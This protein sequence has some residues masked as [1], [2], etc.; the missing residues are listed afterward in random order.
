MSNVG[1]EFGF[2][3][4][5]ISGNVEY[6]NKASIDLIY[7]KPLPGSTGN[8]SITTNIGAI[9]NYGWEIELSSTNIR[10]S[11]FEWKTSLNLSFIKNEITK[12]TQESFVN[13]TK[14]WAVG[15]SLYDFHLVEWAGV[16]PNTGMGMWWYDKVDPNTGAVTREK[17]SDYSLANAEE[18]KRYVGSSL[19]DFTG[20]LNNYFRIGQF[21]VNALF[22]FSFGSKILDYSYS[23]LMSGFASAGYQQSVDV[24][25]AWTKPGD[26]T[27]VPMNVMRQ[28]NNNSTSTRFLFDNDYIRLKSLTLGYNVKKEL[29]ENFGLNGIRIFLQADNLWTWQS[30][31]GIDPEQSLAGTTNSR[32][33]NLK[34]ISLGFNLNF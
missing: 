7:A 4:N 8:T 28:N 9:R 17:T 29:I 15:Q 1:V 31:K 21:D 33:Y 34:T 5:R 14:R 23:S 25:K 26:V 11:N 24:L 27:D 10:K 19:P 32:S 18:S 12:L 2:F 13:G 22:N 30:H 6:F 3:N 20:G 16:D